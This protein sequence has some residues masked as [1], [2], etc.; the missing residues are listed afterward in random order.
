MFLVVGCFEEGMS[1]NTAFLGTHRFFC[2][3][4][5]VTDFLSGPFVEWF[6]LVWVFLVGCCSWFV[7]FAV[8][9]FLL[10]LVCGCCSCCRFVVDLLLYLFL[11]YCY[12]DVIEVKRR[13]EETHTKMNK[14]K[15]TQNI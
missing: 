13:N 1:C 7:F 8:I 15:E 4:S 3:M 10:F 5:N 12:Y 2:Q 11:M 14:I 9:A 6:G